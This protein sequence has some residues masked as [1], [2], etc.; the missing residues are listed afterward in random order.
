MSFIDRYTVPIL[1]EY[2]DNPRYSLTQIADRMNFNSLSYFCRYCK[3]HLGATPT[4][5]RSS[6]QPS[7]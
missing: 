6:L 1:K 7:V 4:E 5:Y 2:L 3:K